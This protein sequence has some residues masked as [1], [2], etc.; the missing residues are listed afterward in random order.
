[1]VA[2][3]NGD[4]P[5]RTLPPLP[6]AQLTHGLGKPTPGQRR[7]VHRTATRTARTTLK[8]SATACLPCATDTGLAH[9]DH[10]VVVAA[11]RRVHVVTDLLCLEML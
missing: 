5:D 9:D 10:A 7:A 3:V 8:R 6:C 11:E 1:M 4:R 2:A